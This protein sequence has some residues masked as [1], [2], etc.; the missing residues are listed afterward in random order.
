[1]PP[2]GERIQF[3]ADRGDGRRR[4]DRAILRHLHDVTPLSRNRV[5][6]WIAD[7]RV[8]VDGVAAH[9][10]SARVRETAVVEVRLP[11]DVGRRLPPAQA[12]SVSSSEAAV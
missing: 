10:S 8:T 4:L 3:V 5:Q 12:T 9:K 2:E 1:M 11:A 6:G 7:E